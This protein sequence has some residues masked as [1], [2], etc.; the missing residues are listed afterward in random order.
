MKTERI[1]I[2][3]TAPDALAEEL[4]DKLASYDLEFLAE[5][6]ENALLTDGLDD[7]DFSVVM[8]EEKTS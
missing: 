2:S 6:L 7:L 3:I 5:G 1:V 4:H 8:E